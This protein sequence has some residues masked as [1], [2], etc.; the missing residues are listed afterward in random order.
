MSESEK[1]PAGDSKP[2][3]V[4]PS[5]AA[6]DTEVDT[7][8]PKF[9]RIPLSQRRGLFA[10]LEIIPEVTDPYQYSTGKKWLMTAIVALAG[11]TSSTGSSIFYPAL[12]GVS[13]DLGTTPTITNLSLAFYMLAMAVTPLWWSM[14]S[15]R[16]GRRTIYLV[17]FFF[18][19]VF[20]AIGAVSVNIAMLVVFR[21]FMGGAAASVQ[22]VGAGTV[23]DVWEPKQRGLAMGV[24]FLG[25]LC[26][27]GIAPIIGGA[28]TQGFGWRS[29]QWYLC[30]FGGVLLLMIL[31]FL[32]ETLKQK[33]AMSESEKDA[34]K[35]KMTVGRFI[36]AAVEPLAVLG[37]LRHPAI[38]VAI[39]A[40]ALSFGVTFVAYVSL[41]ATFLQAPYNFTTI[42]LGLLYLA[43]TIGYA[44]SSVLG[45]KWLDYI[46]VR[47]AKKA[48]RYDEDG[49]LKFLPEDRMKEN[50][51]LS[52]A[53]YPC[54][55]I[56]Y[57]WAADK[58]LHWAISAVALL[59]YGL[60]GMILYGAVTTVLTEFT[61][62]KSSSGI[63][64]NNFV[65]NILST[66][67]AVATQPMIDAMGTGWMATMVGLF[68]LVTI[69]IT[70]GALKIYGPRW[71]VTMDKTLNG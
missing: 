14:Y 42:E 20:S 33:P 36:R 46:M 3:P 34:P 15:E 61:P 28:L 57:G 66:I 29:T 23:A 38:F 16:I 64:L 63:A 27:P 6:S 17:S 39:Y 56:W 32:P 59:L 48:N 8:R 45:G 1:I 19:I 67:A 5:P 44:I 24:F 41:Q 37:L 55:F 18:F 47:E 43:P 51:W 62:K 31:F 26:G 68:A 58:G 21:T 10:F 2:D 25:P 65:R 22:A 30:I 12:E 69:L 40:G 71:R 13:R 9:E 54:M 70:L 7:S 52:A 49:K 35:P 60:F 53:L 4:E 11:T 50:M